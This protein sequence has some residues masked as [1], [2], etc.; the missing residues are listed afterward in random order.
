MAIH[1]KLEPTASIAFDAADAAREL[2]T[3]HFM[4]RNA[5]DLAPFREAIARHLSDRQGDGVTW[6]TWVGNLLACMAGLVSH[7]IETTTAVQNIIVADDDA[8]VSADDDPVVR[9]GREAIL[10]MVCSLAVQDR[11]TF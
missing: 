2:A 8:A 5:G 1:I 9:A 11:V 3:A 10:Q 6:M 7:T 4:A